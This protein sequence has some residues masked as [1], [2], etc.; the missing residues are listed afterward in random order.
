MQAQ[1]GIDIGSIEKELTSLWTQ[2]GDAEGGVIRSCVLNLIV[3]AEG[4][5]SQPALDEALIDITERHPSRAIVVLADRASESPSLEA[6]VTSRC[7]LS[8]ALSKQVCCEQITVHAAGASLKESPS[9]VASLILADLPVYLWIKDSLSFSDSLFKRLAEL[10]NRVIVDSASPNGPPLAEISSY[11]QSSARH[12][13]LIDLNWSRV[14]TWRA[15]I[16]DCWDIEDYR[17]HLNSI[18]RVEIKYSGLLIDNPGVA[19][20]IYYFTG[21]IATRLGWKLIERSGTDNRTT[22]FVFDA[23]SRHVVLDLREIYVGSSDG[24]YI[25]EITLATSDGL[26]LT[27]RRSEDRNRLSSE[28]EFNGKRKST[29]VVGYDQWTDAD[30]LSREM[31]ILGRDRVFEKSAALAYTLSTLT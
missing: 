15:V 3:F 22:S 21:W 20:R 8:H 14:V 24:A 5:K 10:S 23:G 1:A 31:E 2:L 17:P 29:R 6:W 26:S 28:V 11:V 19:A 30:L 12:T 18:E 16:A 25:E 7:S 9:A 4:S 27:A 13:P